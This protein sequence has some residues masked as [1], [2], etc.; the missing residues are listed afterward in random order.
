MP[1]GSI[2]LNPETPYYVYEFRYGRSKVFYVGFSW[3]PVRIHGRWDHVRSLIKR[4]AKNPSK[5][6]K[7]LQTKCNAVIAAL[8]Q[9]GVDPFQVVTPWKVKGRIAAVEQE[10]QQIAL[11]L[12]QGCLL[13]NQQYGPK[14]VTVEMIVD[15][16][17]NGE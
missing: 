8:I 16:L 14:N 10:K 17:A 1:I 12:S 2:A 5:P 13:A 3:H 4:Q 11:R 9:R 6:V 7:S 15:W